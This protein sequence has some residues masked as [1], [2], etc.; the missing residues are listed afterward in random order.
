MAFHDDPQ[1]GIRWHILGTPYGPGEVAPPPAY[2]PPTFWEGMQTGTT[3]VFWLLMAPGI[4]GVLAF[5]IALLA[6]PFH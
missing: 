6:A 5:V 2:R 1:T 3:A 4:V